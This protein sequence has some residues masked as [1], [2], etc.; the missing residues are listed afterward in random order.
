VAERNTLLFDYYG[1]PPSTYEYEWPAQGSPHV[2]TRVR[3]LLTGAGI[4]CKTTN[5]RGLDH[6]VF[7][8]LM[9]AFPQ[10]NVPVL[11]VRSRE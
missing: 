4:E 1:F 8:P 11:Q 5:D 2:A 10:A 9:A 6:G 7:V 3:E